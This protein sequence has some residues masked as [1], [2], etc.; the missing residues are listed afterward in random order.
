MT[1]TATVTF[2]GNTY[3]NTKTETIDALGHDWGT[4]TY[5]WSADNGSVTATRTCSHDANHVETE[6]VS[7]TSAVTT[8]ATCTTA[9]VRTYTSAAFTKSAFTVQMK[10]EEIPATGHSWGMPTWTWTGT[11]SAT[12]TFTCE[13]DS[14]HTYTETTTAITSA[15]GTGA[16]LG[17][18]FYTATISFNNVTYTGTTRVPITYTITYDL[19]GGSMP[20]DWGNPSSYTV[21][22]SDIPLRNPEK[23]GFIFTGWTGTGLNTATTEVTITT[24]STGNRSYTANWT[25]FDPNSFTHSAN[26]ANVDSYL[27][28][29]GNGNTVMLGQLFGLDSSGAVVSDNVKIKIEAVEPNSSVFTGTGSEMSTIES[30]SSAKCVYTKI[31]SDWTQSTLWFTGEGPVKVTIWEDP[32]TEADNGYTLNLEVVNGKNATTATSAT[33]TNIV[34]L[35]NVSGGLSISVGST[36]YGNGFTVTDTRNNPSGTAGYVTINGTADNVRF[37]GYEPTTAV[38]SGT[39]NHGYA[40]SVKVNNGIL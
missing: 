21:E 40:P 36:L 28:R 29:V 11:T 30:G 35:N 18:T 15:A 2:N 12:A 38:T 13:N 16:D 4:P 23:E 25:A 33:N 7:A 26:F 1:Y 17:Y 24:G 37:I 9:G 32:G 19:A 5:V 34:L 3:T 8:A 20:T 27:Y 10:T 22:S 39:N 6:T 14:N 31:S